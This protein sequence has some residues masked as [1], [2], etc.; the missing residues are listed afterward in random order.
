MQPG[1]RA[2]YKDEPSRSR[3]LIE[4]KVE[5]GIWA[6]RRE[7]ADKVNSSHNGVYFISKRHVQ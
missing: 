6:R 4:D 2:K 7:T 1:M 3:C 5:G